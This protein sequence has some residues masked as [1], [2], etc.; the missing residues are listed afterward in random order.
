MLYT[1]IE[2]ERFQSPLCGRRFSGIRYSELH[3]G[4]LLVLVQEA[5][6]ASTSESSPSTRVT[7][8]VSH[9]FGE[10]ILHVRVIRK[11]SRT[12][13][14]TTCQSSYQDDGSL[15]SPLSYTRASRCQQWNPFCRICLQEVDHKLILLSYSPVYAVSLPSSFSTS[16]S[17]LRQGFD[18]CVEYDKRT[19]TNL[20]AIL[21]C[22]GLHISDSLHMFRCR[23][24]DS[25]IRRRH[26]GHGC[27]SPRP[28]CKEY[29]RCRYSHR[30]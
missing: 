7:K 26:I 12:Y 8:P 23:L 9:F 13:T 3:L 11:P 30:T 14:R 16:G 1:S 18:L 25:K 22:N 21:W 27:P 5:A 10:D 2:K 17:S 19:L 28:H 15:V 20:I 4:K 24:W 29:A 6:A